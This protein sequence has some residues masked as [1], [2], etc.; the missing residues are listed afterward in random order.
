M[1]TILTVLFSVSVAVALL[2]LG[3]IGGFIYESS[4]APPPEVQVVTVEVPVE[5]IVTQ[6]VERVVEVVVTPTPLPTPEQAPPPLP[7]TSPAALPAPSSTPESAPESACVDAAW[8]VRQPVSNIG[9]ETLNVEGQGKKLH[10]RIRNIGTCA[11][12]DYVL[13]SGGVFPDIPV[14]P[15]WPGEVADIEYNAVIYSDVEARFVLQPPMTAYGLSEPLMVQNSASP[16]VGLES[17]YYKAEVEEY[18][19][20]PYIPLWLGRQAEKIICGP[21]GCRKSKNRYQ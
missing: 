14:P 12:V 9:D 6:E 4:Q 16:G 19:N 8:V 17:I 20:V 3:W 21:N 2:G 1:K 10:F 18:S 5:R 15:T 7:T 11:W 13:T